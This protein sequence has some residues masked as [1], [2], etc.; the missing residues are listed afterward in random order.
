MSRS[1]NLSP[2]L[3][4]YLCSLDYSDLFRESHLE[5]PE[6]LTLS[7]DEGETGGPVDF[8]MKTYTTHND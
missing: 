6:D 1:S 4:K 2:V 7:A 3:S 8:G 5:E